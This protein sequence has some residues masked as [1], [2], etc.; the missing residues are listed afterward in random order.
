MESFIPP[1]LQVRGCQVFHTL[2]YRSCIALLAHTLL[3]ES[4]KILVDDQVTYFL[5]SPI[6]LL[7]VFKILLSRFLVM[8][9][10]LRMSSLDGSKGL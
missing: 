3:E 6:W 4:E 10:L 5:Y 1:V 7:G 8:T 2:I 9:I